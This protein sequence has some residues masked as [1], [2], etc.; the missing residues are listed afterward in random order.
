M[1]RLQYVFLGI[2]I[3]VLIFHVV[4]LIAQRITDFRHERVRK[5]LYATAERIGNQMAIEYMRR[6][7]E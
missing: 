3:G 2:C 1:I 7:G 6:G 5:S 4:L